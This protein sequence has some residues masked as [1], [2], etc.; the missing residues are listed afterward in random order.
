MS[1]SPD[2][3]IFSQV[4]DRGWLT[5]KA[6]DV[7]ADGPTITSNA[8]DLTGWMPAVVPGTVLTNLVQNGVYP[9]PYVA[10]NNDQIPDIFVT[11]RDFYTYW[12]YATFELPAAGNA[13]SVAATARH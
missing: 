5:I 8:F 11:G 1:N 7:P 3:A 12:F 4:L 2:N 10:Q 6:S 9:D 13:K